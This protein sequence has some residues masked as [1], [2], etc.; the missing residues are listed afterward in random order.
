MD[1][2]DDP[3]EDTMSTVPGPEASRD[4]GLLPADIFTPPDVQ[5]DADQ[6]PVLDDLR[7]AT[8][9][10]DESSAEEYVPAPPPV[11]PREDAN[12]ADVSE[13]VTE[14]PGDERDEY[15]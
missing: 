2:H 15:L 13:Q 1:G 9:G 6:R 11:A 12:E 10:T 14:V 3:R 4:A 8:P 5:R 7:L